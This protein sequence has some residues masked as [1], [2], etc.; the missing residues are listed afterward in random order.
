MA[1]TPQRIGKFEITAVL[2]QGAMGVVYKGLDPHIRRTVAIKTVHKQLLGEGEDGADFAARFRNEAQAVGRLQHPGIVAIHEFGEDADT[3]Y[4]AMEFV[5]G[6]NLEQVLAQ[7]GPLPLARACE[8]VS[9]LLQALACAHAAG[10]W[11]RDIKP[12]N[13]LLTPAGQLKLTD[14]GIARI[15]NMGLTRVASTI[16]TPGCMAPEQYIGEHIDH[17]VDLFAT[18]VL[19]YRL[20]TGQPPFF[21]SAEQVMYKVLHEMPAPPSSLR[22]GLSPAFDALIARALAKPAEHRFQSADEFRQAL[23]LALAAPAATAATVADGEATVVLPR[24]GGAP[25]AVVP[26]AVVPAVPAATVIDEAFRV[27][28]LSVLT[29][30]VGPV[31]RVM[32]KRAGEGAQS[33]AQLV[34]RLLASVDEAERPALKQALAQR[35]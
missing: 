27:H 15:A 4:I 9:Q 19:L 8:L 1:T 23:S 14:F 25:S 26:V 30:H 34:E 35:R 16:G 13:L 20:L 11:H 12:A 6:R 24:G 18:G 32:L 29:R 22:A 5:E 3:A 7:A 2:G 17:R 33:E 21:G 10:V 31:A 28:V